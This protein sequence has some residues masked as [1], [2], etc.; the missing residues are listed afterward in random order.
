MANYSVKF[1]LKIVNEYNSGELSSRALAKKYNLKS[2]NSIFQWKGIYDT[3]GVEELKKNKMRKKWSYDFKYK[4]IKEY[5]ST[6]FSLS[7]LAI[8]YGIRSSAV[9][10]SWKLK[11]DKYGIIGLKDKAKG[12]PS[13]VK[14]KP[15]IKASL[16]EKD[17]FKKLEIYQEA[18][19]TLEIENERLRAENALLEKL[20]ALG[21]EAP[22]KML[23]RSQK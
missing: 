10:A 23:K 5:Y 9:I 18:I 6:N 22:E 21:I 12:R 3:K 17:A 1:K 4:L 7:D 8:K 20:D 19:A 16:S 15:S 2:H 11:Y 13:K 14:K